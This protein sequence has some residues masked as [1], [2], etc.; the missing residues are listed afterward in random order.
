MLKIACWSQI[1]D[2]VFFESK[3]HVS[4]SVSIWYLLV[5]NKTFLL[6]INYGPWSLSDLS[7]WEFWDRQIT[8]GGTTWF[9]W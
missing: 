4:M 8:K 2:Y 3:G 9:L 1:V 6:C 5:C 7:M